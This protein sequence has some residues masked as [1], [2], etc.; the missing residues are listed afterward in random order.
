MILNSWTWTSA[1]RSLE[2]LPFGPLPLEVVLV[3]SAVSL[4]QPDP[5]S[6]VLGGVAPDLL[7]HGFLALQHVL[8]DLRCSD[9]V[10]GR[11][12]GLVEIQS[13]RG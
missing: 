7:Q 2:Y 11:V 12:L 6:P 5:E 13:L 9:R 4:R 10:A 8:P 1:S 3:Q